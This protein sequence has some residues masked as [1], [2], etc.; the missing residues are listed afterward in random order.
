MRLAAG[1]GKTT[2]AAALLGAAALGLAF[3]ARSAGLVFSFWPPGEMVDIGGRRLR[4]VCEG[5]T[6]SAKPVVLFE[7]GA[8]GFSGDWAYAQAAL[9]AQG[10]RSC[11]YDRAGLGLSDPS[12]EPRD[13]INVARDLERLLAAAHVPGPYVLV[14]HSM[15]GARVHLFANRNPDKVAGLVL[16]DS[17]PPEGLDDPLVREYIAKFTAE[18][19]AAAVAASL[20]M[21]KLLAGTH[22]G[23]K[24]G[25]PPEQDHEKRRQF[26]SARYNRIAYEEVVRWPLTAQ[27]A[28]K[29]GPLDPRWPV[30]VITAGIDPGPVGRAMQAAQTPPAKASRRGHIEVVQEA[31]HNGLLSAPFAGSIVRGIDFVLDSVSEADSGRTGRGKPPDS[32][33]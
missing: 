21:L 25:L 8:F 29:T 32:R 27:Q 12:P 2:A 23:D 15:A 6:Q 16:V 7:S 20:G 18:T 19:H 28:R 33:A 14:G 13:G 22:L 30:A 10:L 9:T 24:I 26:A 5:P 31:T 11:A 3:E 1:R 4:L 17:T